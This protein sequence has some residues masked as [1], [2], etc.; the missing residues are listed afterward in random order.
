MPLMEFLW[1]ESTPPM[2][3]QLLKE[4][5][6]K[7]SPPI[8]M[9]LSSREPPDTLRMSSRM[10]L[11]T[12]L[13][14]SRKA[15]KPNLSGEPSSRQSRNQSTPSSW[16]TSRRLSTWEDI[17]QPD[18][19]LQTALGLTNLGSDSSIFKLQIIS[20]DIIMS[21]YLNRILESFLLSTGSLLL[22]LLGS[23]LLSFLLSVLVLGRFLVSSLLGSKGSLSLLDFSDGFLGKSLF[24]FR[25]SGF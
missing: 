25:T 16:R 19:L 17:F 6:L 14:E 22:S 10:H 8:S 23:L 12:D 24:V 15:N 11:S 5:L 21:R 13:R 9:I 20:N 7:V 3:S 2:S 1:E 4:Y 18:S